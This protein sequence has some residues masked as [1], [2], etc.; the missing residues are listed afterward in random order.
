[1]V[2]SGRAACRRQPDQG[3]GVPAGGAHRRRR[4]RHLPDDDAL[5]VIHEVLADPRQVDADVDAARHQAR[6]TARF[7]TAGAAGASRWPRRRPP[8]PGGRRA[9]RS[10]RRPSRTRAPGGPVPAVQH[11][12]QRPGAQQHA[13]VGPVALGRVQVADGGRGP[14]VGVRAVAD[15]EEAGALDDVRVVPG[16][17][18]R[19]AQ[20][21]A[22]GGDDVRHER[23]LV[24]GRH[25]R[26]RR[27]QPLVV[28]VHRV[29][30][31]AR[32]R[33]GRPIPAGRPPGAATRSSCSRWSSRPGSAAGPAGCRSCRAP[34]GRE[35]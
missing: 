26:D 4:R 20:R 1:M 10:R 8:P 34:A 23:V 31:P 22:G 30:V 2:M 13:Q 32:A 14:R 5:G 24:L 17:P 12:P 6:R 7:R 16:R 27:P 35:R 15:L 25:R 3:P 9:R 11:Q 28:R 18:D 33:R 19:Q 21:R 29:G